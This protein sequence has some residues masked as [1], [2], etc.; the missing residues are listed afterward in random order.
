M[1]TPL[2]G[3]KDEPAPP[4]AAAANASAVEVTIV[5][6]DRMP[7]AGDSLAEK[8]AF[9]TVTRGASVVLPSLRLTRGAR[10]APPG[11]AGVSEL[12]SDA[13]RG[14]E[15]L[16]Q[17]SGVVPVGATAAFAVAEQIPRE[18]HATGRPWRRGVEVDV[19]RPVPEAGKE[20]AKGPATAP[21]ADTIEVA[22]A[23]DD[24]AQPDRVDSSAET[25]AGAAAPSP[26]REVA[27]VDITPEAG[28][29]T[30]AFAV[31]FRFQQVS[32]QAVAAIVTVGPAPLGLAG[33]DSWKACVAD[34]GVSR[35][36]VRSRLQ[37]EATAGD[38][39]PALRA[40]LLALYNIDRRRPA[41][42]YLASLTGANLC[43]EAALVA[44]DATL[45]R[46]AG[47]LFKLASGDL[48]DSATVGWLLDQTWLKEMSEQLAGAK[49]S[50]ELSAVLASQTGEVGRH[51]SS[52]DEV[53][54]GAHRLADYESLLVQEN[55]IFLQDSS[56]SARARAFDWLKAKHK[57]PGG[58][59]P[60]GPEQDRHT[61]LDRAASGLP[62][63][64]TAPATAPATEPVTEPSTPSTEPATEPSAT[65]TPATEPAATTWPTTQP[66][67]VP[68]PTTVP[69][70]QPMTVA[71]VTTAPTTRPTV[72]PS[73]TT[74]PSTRPSIAPAAITF[75][76]TKPRVLPTATT[77]PA[78]R[79][80]AGIRSAATR[81]GGPSPAT[82]P[83]PGVRG[84]AGTIAPRM[85]SR[86]QPAT[87]PAVIRQNIARPPPAAS[88]A[89][90]THPTTRPSQEGR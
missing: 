6:L 74:A 50:P 63:L 75:P 5:A 3:A 70:T 54:N 27:I 58:Y 52:I 78:A 8:A 7:A 72:A 87:S 9:L 10:Y 45:A 81:P 79:S 86:T 51:Q 46:V 38:Q 48:P 20:D 56:P 64:T 84:G 36:I 42:I 1:G 28:R 2:S 21:A 80:P 55:T 77:S 11:E 47:K 61:A 71:T 76:T 49:L 66:T 59:D 29:Q 31:P 32:G 13:A 57:E 17:T 90:S 23:V 14:L 18:D 85:P 62:P 82:Q 88:A 43:A 39:G 83:S 24:F 12:Q 44:D 73:A 34:L 16:P 65:T 25:S 22:L 4:P 41:F 35:E 15:L 26:Q 60:L 68:G 67:N 53:A 37:A 69:V 89:P 19:F 40:A 30:L 33:Q